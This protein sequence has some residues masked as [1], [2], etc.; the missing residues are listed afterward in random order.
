MWTFSIASIVEQWQ[1]VITGNLVLA[2]LARQLMF[3]HNAL[4]ALHTHWLRHA[5]SAEIPAVCAGKA[6]M[7][8]G[9]L[10]PSMMR[11]SAVGLSKCLSIAPKMKDMLRRLS[12]LW[13]SVQSGKSQM[14]LPAVPH[15]NS[16]PVANFPLQ[17][18]QLLRTQLSM[19][20]AM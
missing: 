13:I 5:G 10:C 3:F 2:K 4:Q 19:N 15:C 20:K 11:K 8:L 12:I 9:R 7:R 17:V 14:S 16:I 1:N 6:S 18:V